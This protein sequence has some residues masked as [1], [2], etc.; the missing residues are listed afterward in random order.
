MVLDTLKKAKAADVGLMERV[1][2]R[3]VTRH[4]SAGDLAVLPGDKQCGVTVLVEGMPFP[5]EE[6]FALENKRRHP[7]GI[8]SVNAPREFDEC[9]TL[10]AS[11][12]WRN[13]NL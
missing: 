10:F 3:I 7:G 4:D 2:I 12:D 6:C 8:V 9:V 1:V 11:V 13:F 5:I